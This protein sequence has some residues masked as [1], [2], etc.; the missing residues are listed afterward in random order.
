MVLIS[1][2]NRDIVMSNRKKNGSEINFTCIS[3]IFDLVPCTAI[4]SKITANILQY[5]NIKDIEQDRRFQIYMGTSIGI[6]SQTHKNLGKCF[7]T[8][9]FIA[10]FSLIISVEKVPNSINK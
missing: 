5:Q 2:S 10:N 4:V 1:I 3:E 6:Q 7:A 8:S 9:R